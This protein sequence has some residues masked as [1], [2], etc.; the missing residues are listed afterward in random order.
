MLRAWI[1]GLAVL[2]GLAG[3]GPSAP[4]PTFALDDRLVPNGVSSQA[5]N[6]PP[7]DGVADLKDTLI[8]GLKVTRPV[9]IAW[10]DR[11]VLKV[12][13][14]RLPRSLVLSTFKWARKQHGVFPFPYF[15]QGLRLRAARLGIPL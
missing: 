9:D 8:A 3:L 14:G 7:S 2:S 4:A 13:Q 11:V 6:I 10:I 12:D 1:I 5:D 15:K